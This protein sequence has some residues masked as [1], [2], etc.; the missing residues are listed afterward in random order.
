MVD[1]A[2]QGHPNSLSA[3][4]LL[5]CITYGGLEHTEPDGQCESTFEDAR[6]GSENTAAAIA[7]GA[8][9]KDLGPALA[10]DFGA[11][12]ATRPDK[13]VQSRIRD[14]SNAYPTHRT[15]WPTRPSV[16]QNSQVQFEPGKPTVFHEIP[17]EV[18]IQT[19]LL[20]PLPDLLAILLLSAA[21]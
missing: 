9:G 12:M 16:P 19:L 6:S 3:T 2:S 20:L 8:Q 13:S 18:L 15:N 7:A 1:Y 11:W 4:G 10:L 5:P 17:P 14:D 21:S